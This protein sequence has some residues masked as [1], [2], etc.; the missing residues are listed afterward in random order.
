MPKGYHHVTRDIRCQIYALK[1]T[2]ISL[3]AIAN[4]LG[5]NA[6]TI[7][8]EITRNQGRLSYRINQAD[9]M[10]C[11]RRSMASM[12]PKKLTA[13]LASKIES[14]IL[15]D[16]SP[17]QIAG[18]L[19]LEEGISISYESIYRYIWANK[20]AG[21]KLHKHLRHCGKRY[22]K[23][24]SSTA[25]RGCIPGRIDITTRPVIVEDKARIGDWEGDTVISAVSKTALLTVV[26]R[27]SK[28][29]VIKKIGRKTAD[30]V[31]KA[32]TERLRSLPHPV[33]TITY[34]NGMEFSAHAKISAKLNSAAYFAAPYHS[35]ER[36]LNEHTNGLI[37]QYLPKAFDFR[38]VTNREIKKI[39]NK[40]N[41]RP[42]KALQYRTPNEVFF[43][44]THF[45]E[46]V[47]L[48]C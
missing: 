33:H 10:A 24:A 37:R 7:C 22:N 14:M 35:W 20:R 40:L 44:K 48:R 30:N 17:E 39:E 27:C 42:R 26:D 31:R 28:F 9:T 8:R 45:T 23:R 43:T 3:R 46:S 47:A 29:V 13:S 34:D 11:E 41:N 36:G 1:A 6:S 21:G 32:M 16:W 4:K 12:T 2:G 38:N 25:G 18:R 15:K 5:K 19:R